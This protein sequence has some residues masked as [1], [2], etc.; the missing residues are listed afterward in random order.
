[1]PH[2]VMPPF[3]SNK[4]QMPS[5]SAIESNIQ[6]IEEKSKGGYM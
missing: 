6:W 3:D 1:M 2:L 4:A 5:R